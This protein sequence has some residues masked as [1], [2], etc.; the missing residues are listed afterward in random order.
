VRRVKVLNPPVRVHLS[1]VLNHIHLLL[2]LAISLSSSTNA[3]GELLASAANLVPGKV[4][5]GV[6][7][8][9]ALVCELGQEEVDPAEADGGDG[10]EKEHC[11]AGGHAYEH[12]RDGFG[13]SVFWTIVLVGGEFDGRMV[14]L[15]G[16]TVDEVEGHGE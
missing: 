11:S 2:V 13:V 10:D 14:R 7:G 15:G 12:E 3:L 6:D 16:R 9:E 1:N 8:L 5:D 4:E